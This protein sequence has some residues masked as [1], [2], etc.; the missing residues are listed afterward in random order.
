MGWVEKMDPGRMHMNRN[1]V[2]TPEAGQD[3]SGFSNT[4]PPYGN[5]FP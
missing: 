3:P 5:L 4:E 1:Q 2:R